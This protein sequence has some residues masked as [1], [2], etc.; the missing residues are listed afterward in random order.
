MA[1]PVSIA[2]IQ[3][4]A[5]SEGATVSKRRAFHLEQIERWLHAAG[6]AGADVAGLGETCTTNWVD[7]VASDPAIVEDAYAGPTAELARSLARQYRMHV[8]LPIAAVYA[9]RLQNLALVLDRSG[10]VVGH[11][12]KVHPTRIELASGIVEG[13]SLPVFDLDFGRIGIVI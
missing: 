13:D 7:A 12:A 11:Y 3:L 9:G 5:W 2:A 4:P 6:R 1:R 8:I 10:S